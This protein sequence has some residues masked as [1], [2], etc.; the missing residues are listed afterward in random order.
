MCPLVLVFCRA[1]PPLSL[2]ISLVLP[3]V[4]KAPVCVCVCVLGRDIGWSTGEGRVTQMKSGVVG[5]SSL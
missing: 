4:V 3:V 2:S 5:Q 1:D